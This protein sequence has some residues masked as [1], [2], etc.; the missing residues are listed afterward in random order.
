MDSGIPELRAKMNFREDIENREYQILDKRATKSADSRGRMQPE[1]KCEYRT[2]FQRDRDRIIHS[3]SFRRLMQ[4]T[5]VFLAPEGDHYRTR[6]THTLEVAQVARTIARILNYNEDLTEAIALGHDLGHT[7]FGHNGE[8]VL[9]QIHPGGF[10]HRVQSL[11]VVDVLES[12]SK[13][14]GLN[15]TAEVRDGI[16]NHS[17]S[18]LP[19]TLEGQIVRY[20]DRI[21]YIN[22][23]IDDAIRSGVLREEELP[24]ENIQVLGQSHSNRINN[25]IDDI[26]HASEGKDRIQLSEPFQQALDELRTFMFRNVYESAEVK[27]EADL[28]KVEMVITQLYDYFL[29]HEE[30]LPEQYRRIAQEDGVQEAVKDYISG[31]T[32][33]YA[34]SLY[35]DLF[36]PKFWKEH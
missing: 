21:A 24:R 14:R 31:M 30:K 22:H 9:N 13:R 29:E 3:K 11:R 32:D 34:V 27:R 7:P 5:Q 35:S 6:L 15:L 33:R 4:K 26:V 1:E 18:D 12:T 25:L 8:A 23:D 28:N 17:G 16:L 19:W 2:A 20:S 10:K 36:V